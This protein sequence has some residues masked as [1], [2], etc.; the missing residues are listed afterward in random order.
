L[1]LIYANNWFN[2]WVPK[3]L[4]G[5]EYN[6]VDGLILLEELAYWDAGFAWTVTLCSGANMFAGFIEPNTAISLFANP[7][8]CLG[9]SG[10]SSGKAKQEGDNYIITGYWKYATGSPHL[11][12][13]TLNAEV[14]S[15]N[16]EVIL[17]NGEPLILSFLVPR[18]QVL[19]HYDWDSFGLECTASHS[20]SVDQ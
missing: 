15:E 20:F 13:F 18:D 10:A 11:T 3:S 16:N 5:G 1:A 9:G 6:L 2:I 17:E 12:H 19:V 14:I 8:I 7:K 4:S